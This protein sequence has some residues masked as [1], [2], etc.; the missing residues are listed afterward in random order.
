LVFF[1]DARLRLPFY[2]FLTPFAGYAL[3]RAIVLWRGRRRRAVV[4]ALA[5]AIAA[6]VATGWVVTQPTPRDR[7]RLA[8]V[9]S[10]QGRLDEAIGVLEPELARERPDPYVLD[11]AGWIRQKGGELDAARDLY[12]RA[13]ERNDPALAPSRARQVRTRLAQVYEGLGNLAEARRQHDAAV[14]S[15]HANAGTFYERGMFLIRGGYT[16]AG[17]RDLQRAVRLDP[18]WEAPRAALRA[19]GR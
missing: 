13:L 9:L 5:V 8:S 15:G 16:E 3:D 19:L 14:A 18:G 2:L 17:A 11:H 7:T 1:V 10:I 4:A 12:L 6:A